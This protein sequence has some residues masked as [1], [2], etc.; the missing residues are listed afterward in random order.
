MAYSAGNKIGFLASV[1]AGALIS[2]SALAADTQ[3]LSGTH[4][5]PANTSAATGTGS[6]TVAADKSVSG[7]VTVTG[8]TPTAA[9]IHEAAAGKNGGVIVP[10][11]KSG[12]NTFAVPAGTVLSDAQYAAYKA[13][14]LYVNVHS[15]TNPGGEVRAQLTPAK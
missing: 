14:N 1:F 9:H 2:V 4:E 7:S 5:V 6:I 3:T 8:M 13:G 11:T 15:K 12:D 10:L